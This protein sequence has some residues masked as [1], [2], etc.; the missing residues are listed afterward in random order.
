MTFDMS[1]A[2]QNATA[3]I[4]ANRDVLTVIAGIF[5]F[6]PALVT[7]FAIPPVDPAVLDDPA[8]LQAAFWASYSDWFWLSA[9]SMLMQVT[10]ILAMLVLL[11]DRR[12]PTVAQ[13]L[14]A[15]LKALLPAIGTG[16]VMAFGIVL[17]SV[18]V[19][20]VIALL[21]A[22]LGVGGSSI[23]SLVSTIVGAFFLYAGIRLSLWT[24]VIAVDGVRNPITVL[25]RSWRM[26]RGNALRLAVFFALLVVV[27]FVVFI[28][29]GM[30][31][32][33]LTLVL[34]EGA[35]LIIGVLVGGLVG[36]LATMIF[37]SV[38]A[39]IHRQLSGPWAAP[40]DLPGD[41]EG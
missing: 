36:A 11:R 29:L 27:Y 22:S 28:I 12:R 5:F 8:A 3:M 25:R 6:L 15:G 1:K 14:R 32:S 35:G 21:A 7:G 39:A 31:T 20:T 24:P 2:W 40:M 30:L 18:A 41:A 4:K 38:T 16:L 26:T 23:V 34:G 17:V 10:G 19:G 33:A 13:A 9:L 37:T